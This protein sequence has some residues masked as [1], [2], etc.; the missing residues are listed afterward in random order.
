MKFSLTFIIIVVTVSFLHD[1]GADGV[2]HFTHRLLDRFTIVR[3]LVTWSS[4]VR[5]TSGCTHGHTVY[6]WSLLWWLMTPAQVT[7]LT[8]V[9]APWAEHWH[10]PQ[11][12]HLPT[13]PPRSP[14]ANSCLL[15]C[16]CQDTGLVLTVDQRNA[17]SSSSI[18]FYK[19][20]FCLSEWKFF[21]IFLAPYWD[22]LRTQYWEKHLQ[23]K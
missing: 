5:N 12:G 7:S 3:T 20:Y 18:L 16:R 23:I 11:C 15:R 2:W 1:N 4:A 6:Q 21:P 10:L 13:L 9:T 22:D 8:L 14:G 19:F 17:T